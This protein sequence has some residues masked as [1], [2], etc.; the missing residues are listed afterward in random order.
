MGCKV[1][2]KVSKLILEKTGRSIAFRIVKVD[3]IYDMTTRGELNN[4]FKNDVH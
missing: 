4:L 1:R 2:Q 3:A